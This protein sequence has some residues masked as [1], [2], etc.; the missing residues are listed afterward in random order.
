MTKKTR[1]IIL[2]ICAS[3]F[4]IITPM[5]IFYSLGYRI[6][7]ENK[8]VVATGGIYVK[9]NPLGA[10]ITIDSRTDKKTNIFSTYVFVQNLIPK[11][12]SVTIKKD[13]YFEYQKTLDVK[14]NE[15]T[16]LEH[17]TLFKKDLAFSLVPSDAESPFTTL[18]PEPNYTLKN[19]NLYAAKITTPII[20]QIVAF[21][22]NGGLLWLS[23]DG[24]IYQ[25][26]QIGENVQKLSQT[27]LTI[28]K[29]NTYQLHQ[30]GK[31]IFVKENNNLLLLSEKTGEF[32]PFASDIIDVKNSPDNQ[33]MAYYS[34]N[35]LGIY[36]ATNDTD[37][38]DHPQNVILKTTTEPLKN[39]FWINSDYV[40]LI[41]ENTIS[42][43][44]IDARNNVNIVALP[45]TIQLTDNQMISLK[46][47]QI[48]FNN[49]DKKI[50]LLSGKTTLVSERLIP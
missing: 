20:K 21:E 18:K 7:F 47:A 30:F 19:N 46:D 39:I 49:T 17:V 36:Y 12:H 4:V 27:P 16:K 13:G 24:F 45:E 6:D 8:K 3:L 22:E 37:S 38:Y 35:T 28:N 26:N 48:L 42:I 50:Y 5:I 34:A 33:K 1:L 43:V 11:K 40:L 10:E 15:V 44:E 25:S 29:K 14:E 41:T 31:N 23:T 32:T 2:L 9:A